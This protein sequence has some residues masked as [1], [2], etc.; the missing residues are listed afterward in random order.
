MVFMPRPASFNFQ[1]ER[2][3][4]KRS[5]E[6]DGSQHHHIGKGGG[7]GDRADNVAR[8]EKFE[9]QQDR[10]AQGLPIDHVSV[11]LPEVDEKHRAG[12]KSPGD[13]NH[14]AGGINARSH[15]IHERF[16]RLH[17]SGFGF[18]RATV[19]RSREEFCENTPQTLTSVI[20]FPP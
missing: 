13:D 12:I 5:D 18:D 10:P 14:N 6:D 4:Q 17:T 8:H 11:G 2:G 7:D 16:K 3:A 9:P 1:L 15:R 19:C 20:A